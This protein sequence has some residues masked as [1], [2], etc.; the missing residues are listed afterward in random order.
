MITIDWKFDK[1]IVIVDISADEDYIIGD[2]DADAVVSCSVGDLIDDNEFD[3]DDDELLEYELVDDYDDI[4]YDVNDEDFDDEGENEEDF[5]NLQQQLG[6]QEQQQQ[7]GNQDQKRTTID[8]TLIARTIN[9]YLSQDGE[10]SLA[11]QIA[12]LH[13]IEVTTPEFDNVLRDYSNSGNEEEGGGG[14]NMFE[15][16]KGFDVI[17]DYWEVPKQK[18]KKKKSGKAGKDVVAVAEEESATAEE[19]DEEEEE[20]LQKTKKVIEGKL[21]GRDNDKGVTMVNVKGR[22]TKIKNDMIDC[23]KLPKAKRE[24]GVK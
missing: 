5:E 13:E 9:E 4:D 17:V 15:V 6:L 20:Q 10:D 22:I 18:K 21:V 19:K 14:V 12:K 7:E 16:Y 1:I 24:K 8:L 11:F 23:V 3:D 2:D